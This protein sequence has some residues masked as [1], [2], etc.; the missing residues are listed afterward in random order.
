MAE[1]SASAAQAVVVTPETTP[2][3]K[4][5]KPLLLVDGVD[6]FQAKEV[7]DNPP[8]PPRTFTLTAPPYGLPHQ[9]LS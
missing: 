3:P 6:P 5:E 4:K 2:A 7:L 1:T 8:K 9:A